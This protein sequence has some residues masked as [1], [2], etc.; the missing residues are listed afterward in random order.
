MSNQFSYEFYLIADDENEHDTIFISLLKNIE[1]RVEAPQ[2][3]IAI[4]PLY[5]SLDLSI[6]KN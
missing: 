1:Q 2:C 3:R 5:L 4:S 6:C